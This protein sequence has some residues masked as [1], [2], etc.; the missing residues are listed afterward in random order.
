MAESAQEWAKRVLDEH[1]PPPQRLVEHVNR[2]RR[3]HAKT[4]SNPQ[5]K[6]TA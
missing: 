1:G 6:R 4:D 5:G 3:E 2:L